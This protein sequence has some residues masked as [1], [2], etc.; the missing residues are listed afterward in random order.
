MDGL[1]FSPPGDSRR[2]F[3]L[4]SKR[5]GGISDAGERSPRSTVLPASPCLSDN[6]PGCPHCL[7]SKCTQRAQPQAYLGLGG[8]AGREAAPCMRAQPWRGACREGQPLRPLGR[9]VPAAAQVH[10]L[11]R[12]EPELS[13]SRRKTPENSPHQ[14]QILK[15]A[16]SR[17]DSFR[18]FLQIFASHPCSV[19]LE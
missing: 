5:K 4:F 7:A 2:H 1:G 18:S 12:C 3:R 13:G 14:P 10:M 15:A 19:L 6:V 17:C 9:G 11:E 8:G 16:Q